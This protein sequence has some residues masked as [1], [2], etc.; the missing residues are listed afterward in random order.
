M[1]MRIDDQ[2]DLLRVRLSGS[3]DELATDWFDVMQGRVVRSPVDILFD[4]SDVTYIDSKGL[5]ALFGFT[6]QVEDVGRKAFFCSL[7]EPVREVFELAGLEHILRVHPDE[8]DAL[9]AIEHCR[10]LR[11]RDTDNA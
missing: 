7:S 8:A 5:G 4:L 2:P 3:F 1:E 6:K 10:A 9:R 11:S